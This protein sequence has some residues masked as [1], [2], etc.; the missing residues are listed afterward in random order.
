M[1]ESLSKL[2]TSP[3]LK[4]GLEFLKYVIWGTG[5]L[6]V[7]IQ[8]ISL[9]VRSRLLSKDESQFEKETQKDVDTYVPQDHIPDIEL[10][11][12]ATSAMDNLEEHFQRFSKIGVFSILATLLQQKS[13]GTV[14]LATSN[15]H[16]HP[17]VDFG[18]LSDPADYDIA[19]TATRLSIKIGEKIKAAGFPLIRNLTYPEEKQELDKKNGNSE[20]MDKLI[21]G[22]IRTTYHYAC[23]CRMAAEDDV[24]APGVVSEELKVHGTQN[25]RIADTSVFPQIV[26][27]HLQAPAVMVAER[28]ADFILKGA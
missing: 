7:P 10:M 8:P 9:F 26:A 13:R 21:R 16:D 15:H 22:R 23:S 19:R 2:A 11:P 12:L 20:E 3:V 17:K 5:L 28:C 4:G 27:T 25:V 14:R 6:G 1:N 18:L 24:K